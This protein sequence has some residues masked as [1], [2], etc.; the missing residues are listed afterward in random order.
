MSTDTFFQ[1]PS[2][3]FA[4]DENNHCHCPKFT[5]YFALELCQYLAEEQH[6]F[7]KQACHCC[8]CPQ[9]LLQP[10]K[11]LVFALALPS[12]PSIP[13]LQ[14]TCV[15]PQEHSHCFCIQN[16]LLPGITFWNSIWKWLPDDRQGLELGLK[17]E[18][19]SLTKSDQ[20]VVKVLSRSETPN[21][22]CGL[23]ILLV[24]M[25]TPKFEA[26]AIPKWKSCAQNIGK[27]AEKWGKKSNHLSICS[28]HAGV[29]AFE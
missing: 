24:S 14:P 22:R 9:Q 25:S 2:I 12:C 3:L 28:M 19:S 11:C 7:L 20:W 29:W 6:F 16:L 13:L 17:F 23:C 26:W 18:L 10:L 4:H 27:Q 1:N 5:M 21:K 8:S 15:L